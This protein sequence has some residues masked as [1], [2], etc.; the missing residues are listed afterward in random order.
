MICITGYLCLVFEF[1]LLVLGSHPEHLHGGAMSPHPAVLKGF[2]MLSNIRARSRSKA[3]LKSRRR[4]VGLLAVVLMAALAW[5]VYGALAAQPAVGLGTSGSFAVLAASAVTN[6]GPSTINGELGVSPGT[7]VT[8]FPPGTAHGATHAADAAA[9]QAQSDLTVAYNDAASRTPAVTV[10]GDLGGLTLT[11]GVY[12]SGSSLG[13]TGELTL[14]AQ[15]NADAV[16]VFQAGSTLT[17]ASGSSITL[18]NGAQACNVYWQIGSSATL[19]TSSVFAGNILAHTSISMNNAVTVDGRAL[20]RVGAVTLINDTISPSGCST[21][22]STAPISS[23]PATS[24]PS[25]TTP[26]GTTPVKKSP[27]KTTPTKKGTGKGT[28]KKKKTV[29]TPHNGVAVF[30]TLPRSVVSTIDHYGTS[31]CVLRTFQ[32]GVTGLFIRQV[33]FSLGNKVIATRDKA[34]YKATVVVLGGVRLIT[35]HVTYTDGTDPAKLHLRFKA[36]T[37]ASVATVQPVSP[38]HPVGFTG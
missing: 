20:A 27:T 1:R 9:A 11:P 26:S 38:P 12:K 3:L 21:P 22:K 28:P 17:T 16:F 34:P 31:R 6:T 2:P 36:C 13:L 35:A 18:I 30:T 14:D 24:S 15:G 19:G 33:V 25:G 8:G 32:V 29:A 5:P 37:A 4:Q 7:A 23:P 10:A